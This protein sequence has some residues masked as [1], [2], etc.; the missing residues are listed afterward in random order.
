MVGYDHQYSLHL[1]RIIVKYKFT[2]TTKNWTFYVYLPTNF[3]NMRLKRKWTVYDSEELDLRNVIQLVAVN[4][5]RRWSSY[6]VEDD[7][8]GFTMI[9]RQEVLTKPGNE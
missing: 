8:L 9:D 4:N 7:G 6:S 1:R 5:K 3:F 2:N